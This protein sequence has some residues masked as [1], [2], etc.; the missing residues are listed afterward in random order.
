[1]FYFSRCSRGRTQTLRPLHLTNPLP[2]FSYLVSD[3]LYGIVEMLNHC[4]F[5]LLSAIKHLSVASRAGRRLVFLCYQKQPDGWASR[6][7]VTHNRRVGGRLVLDVAQS[8]GRGCCPGAPGPVSLNYLSFLIARSIP[9]APYAS[10]K[11]ARGLLVLL[12]V[13]DLRSRR[14]TSALRAAAQAPLRFL[15][16]VQ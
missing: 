15:C 6:L 14:E 5:T 9:G 11:N 7:G 13:L 8:P 2:Q 1:M 3:L 4:L 12:L 16:R 10:K